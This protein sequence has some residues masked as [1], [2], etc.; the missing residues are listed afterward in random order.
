ME[1]TGVKK[2]YGLLCLMAFFYSTPS[3]YA[4]HITNKMAADPDAPISQFVR[5]IFQDS[6]GNHWFGTN[7]DGVI[8][9]NGE[10]L[11]YF[12]IP[13]GFGGAAVRGIVEDKQGNVWFGTSGGV[14]KYDGE[15]FT[16]YD[17]RDGLIHHDVWSISIDSQGI[18]WI[19]T[20]LG[21]S[22]FD[23]EAFTDFDLPENMPDYS[24]GVTSTRIV[25][26]IME[27]RAGKMWFGTSGGAYVSDGKSL[28]YISAQDGLCSNSV[29]CIL[30]DKDGRYWF[31]THHNG[32]CR[33]DGNSFTHINADDGVDG[34]EVWNIYEDRSG[35]IWFPVEGFGVYRYDG[36]SFANFSKPEGLASQAIQCTY[37]DRDRRIWC[38]G[39]LGLFSFDGESFVGVTNNGPWQ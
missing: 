4:Q 30:E 11:E 5:R 7:G 15:S 20:L 3:A 8:R 13:E 31:A 6:S 38:G 32:V 18:I 16:N 24:R 1:R 37:E 21:V 39:W 22:R 23:G 34:T 14:T 17:E 33:W 9:H 19:G 12:S 36:N 28:A 2:V 25:H 27:D 35:N 26:C 10:F 29:N